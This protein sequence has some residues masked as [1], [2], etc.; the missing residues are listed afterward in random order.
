MREAAKK[1]A[2]SRATIISALAKEYDVIHETFAAGSSQRAKFDSSEWP[3]MK[4]R[5]QYHAYFPSGYER[6]WMIAFDALDLKPEEWE[7]LPNKGTT[8]VGGKGVNVPF[9]MKKDPNKND[10][11]SFK[12][13][14]ETINMDFYNGVIPGNTSTATVVDTDPFNNPIP[15]VFLSDWEDLPALSFAGGVL[16][17]H[18]HANISGMQYTPDSAEIEAKKDKYAVFQ[19]INGALLVGNGVFLEDGGTGDFSMIAISYNANTFD[20]LKTGTPSSKLLRRY[21]QELK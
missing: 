9:P 19:Y 15:N 21:W 4:T 10:Y 5:D 13:P 18:A 6:G 12:V 3:G 7:K 17:M 1:S 8:I 2:G 20:Q 14:K 11:A 16:D